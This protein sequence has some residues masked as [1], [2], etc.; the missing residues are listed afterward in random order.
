MSLRYQYKYFC[1]KDKF[2]RISGNTRCRSLKD[3]RSMV[4][5]QTNLSRYRVPLRAVLI[6]PFV[7][8]IFATVGLVGYLSFR[9][10]QGAINRLANQLMGEIDERVNQHLDSY[11]AVPQ[12]LNQINTDAASSKILDI[13]NLEST[14]RYFWQQMQVYKNLSYIFSLLPNGEYTGA[15]RWM[16]GGKTTIDEISARTNYKNYT[17]A[18]DEQGNRDKVVFKAEYKPLEEY[19]YKEAIQTG[20]PIWSK[21]YNWQDTPEFISISASRPVYDNQKKLIGVMASDILLSNISTFLQQLKV[22][23]T[24]TIFI[25]ERDGNIVA[26]SSNEKPF[27]LVNRTARRLNAVNSTNPLIKAAAIRFTKKIW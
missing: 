19:W 3:E 14:G 12:Q 26:S 22:S 10:G 18:T 20:K 11:L 21:I 24:G 17:Y 9:N 16:E 13:Q 7:L 4:N 2:I 27:T 5:I 23:Q 15:G 8:Q 25:L 6:V 1:Y